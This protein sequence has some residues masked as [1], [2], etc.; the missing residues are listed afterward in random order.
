MTI[1][2]LAQ[3]I[4][5]AADVFCNDRAASVA[6][7]QR[8]L[9]AEFSAM[10]QALLFVHG[11]MAT[12]YNAAEIKVIDA[13]IGGA[14]PEELLA[15]V[16]ARVL[17]R[18]LSEI[19]AGLRCFSCEVPYSP[20]IHSQTCDMAHREHWGHEWVSQRVVNLTNKLAQAKP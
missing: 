3:K 15:A 13:V 20:A 11:A 4:Q 17:A 7:I 12:K 10:K 6:E 19:T 2:P 14:S 16:D 18:R 1:S 5:T 9:D 8:L